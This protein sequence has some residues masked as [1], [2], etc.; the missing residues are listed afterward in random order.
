MTTSY[1]PDGEGGKRPDRCRH[2]LRP[3]LPRSFS[4]RSDCNR[5]H[6]GVPAPHRPLRLL[7]GQGPPLDPG[8]RQGR[9]AALR[10]CRTRLRRGRPSHR[11]GK[12][13]NQDFSDIRG[14][15]F[16]RDATP[17]AF[18]RGACR[19]SR[20]A[21][22]AR[23]LPRKSWSACP[24]TSRSCDDAEAYAR[25]SR[26]LHRESNPGNARPLVQRHGDRD[27]WLTPPPIPL[28]TRRWTRST[29]CLMRA[30]RIPPMATRKSPP[31]T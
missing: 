27:L 28:T 17:E 3:A 10:Q 9:P 31:G 16:M 29:I 12:G 15:A 5:R 22:M 18:D 30:R 1:T 11:Q 24:P 2:R 21:T 25:A 13:V 7:V 8:R 23:E 19:R 4:R 20:R 26:V 6:R 14:L